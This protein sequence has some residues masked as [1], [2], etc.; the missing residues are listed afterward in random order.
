MQKQKEMLKKHFVALGARVHFQKFTARQAS[1]GQEVEMANLIVSWHADRKR[2]VILCSHYDT[3][4]IADQEE[5]IRKWHEPF[6]SAN[7]G[8]SGVALL[9]ELGNHMRA[10]K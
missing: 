7:D 3:R 10:L 5:N 4:P 9:M 8:G 2:R 1:R 6:V